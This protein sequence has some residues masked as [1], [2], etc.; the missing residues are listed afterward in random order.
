MTVMLLTSGALTRR[1]SKL[2][3]IL[4]ATFKACIYSTYLM[5]FRD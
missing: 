1:L 4:V 5:I 2:D 3:N